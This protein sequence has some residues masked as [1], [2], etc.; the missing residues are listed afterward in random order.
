LASTIT[1]RLSSNDPNL[2]NIPIRTE[3]GRKIRN[4]FV[5]EKNNN[6]VS[7]DYSQIEL[8][9][10]AEIS[11]DQNL[12]NEFKK[13]E[14]IHTSTA[15]KI[16]GLNEKD[17]NS[18]H[19]R[20]AKAINFGIIYGISPYGLA[21]QLSITN[22]EGKK[23]IDAYFK[24]FPKIKEYMNNQMIYCRKNQYVQTIFGRKCFIRGINDK[25]FALRGFSERQSINAPIQGSAADIIK[26]AMIKIHNEIEQKKFQA[27][28]LLQVHDELIF[29]I[30]KNETKKTISKIKSIMETAHLEYKEFTVPLIVEYG[31]GNNWGESH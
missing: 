1:G 23:Y 19:R 2:Q 20:K 31:I 7:F 30:D 9:L 8:R 3:N 14:D 28:M 22:T 16:F 4:A 17:V 5:P 24:R 6:I 26:L 10:A 21:K 25:N 12:I 11:K 27:K 18:D 15:A 13:G 29:E